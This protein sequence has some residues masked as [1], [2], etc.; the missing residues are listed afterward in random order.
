MRTQVLWKVDIQEQAPC[1]D[2]KPDP[3]TGA[4]PSTH[5]AVYHF[6]QVT[7]DM[8]KSFPTEEEADAFIA[9][10]PAGCYGFVKRPL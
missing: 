3:Y 2:Y 7:R 6:R 5:C 4:Y 9:A 10:A 1:P 8:D